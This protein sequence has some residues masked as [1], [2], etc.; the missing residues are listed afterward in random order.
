[1]FES[2]CFPTG[3]FLENVFGQHSFH[4]KM[5]PTRSF[6]RTLVDNANCLWRYVSNKIFYETTFGQQQ[7]SF[8]D[9]PARDFMKTYF[10]Q[11]NFR[12]EIFPTR[13]SVACYSAQAVR[14]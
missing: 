10:E 14:S 9:L 2:I 6:M 1:M 7:F 4:G 8:Q 12:G 11:Q 5:F 3:F 13:T